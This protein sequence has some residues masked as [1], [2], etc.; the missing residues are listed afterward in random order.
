MT[1]SDVAGHLSY[2]ISYMLTNVLWLRILR[3][4]RNFP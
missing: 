2:A 1:W 4:R 3:V